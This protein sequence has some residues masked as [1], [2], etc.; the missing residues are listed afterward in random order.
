M[1]FN[2]ALEHAV[3]SN[4][5]IYAGKLNSNLQDVSLSDE[6][7]EWIMTEN[8][9]FNIC[10]KSQQRTTSRFSWWDW[11]NSPHLPRRNSSVGLGHWKKILLTDRKQ[12]F[13]NWRENT[14]HSPKQ[15]EKV[16]GQS[17]WPA[18]HPTTRKSKIPFSLPIRWH[19][20][21]L[22]LWKTW[23]NF[24]KQHHTLKK[25]SISNFRIILCYRWRKFSKTLQKARSSN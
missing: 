6:Q 18:D 17:D 11:I 8:T 5:K 7:E 14:K 3:H 24:M 19:M 25:F 1:F 15:M 23:D 2:N 21:N 9:F 16:D 12:W 4:S 20:L 13:T 10:T 22:G